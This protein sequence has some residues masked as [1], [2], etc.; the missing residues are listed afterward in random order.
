[1]LNKAFL[2]G[3]ITQDLELRHTTTGNAVL[4]FTIAVERDYK[5]TTGERLTD[6]IDVVAWKQEA[7]FIA[8]NFAKGRSIIVSGALQVRT[9]QDKDGN[10]R[11]NVEVIAEQV[12]FTGEGRKQETGNGYGTQTQQSGY[13]TEY[14]PRASRDLA[15]MPDLSDLTSMEDESGLPF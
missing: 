9:W 11:R 15:G 12:W 7:E 13:G 4:S 1:M 8:R 14:S 5:S 6:F 10:R 3:R 2:M